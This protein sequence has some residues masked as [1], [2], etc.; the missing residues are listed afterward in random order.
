MAKFG[1]LPARAPESFGV[2][3]LLGDRC[4]VYYDS[5]FSTRHI[6][7]VSD[8]LCAQLRSIGYGELEL[9]SALLFGLYEGYRAQL[10]S[11]ARPDGESLPEPLVIECGVDS[12]KIAVGVSFTLPPSELI[13]VSKLS[14]KLKNASAATRVEKFVARMFA[15]ADQVVIRYQPESR[16]ME[17]VSMLGIPGKI[18]ALPAIEQR[19]LEIFIL[20]PDSKVSPIN[21]EYI[22]LADLDYKSLLKDD[23]PGVPTDTPATGEI[24]AKGV[25]EAERSFRVSG[26]KEEKEKVTRIS[27]VTEHM[28]AVPA[29]ASASSDEEVEVFEEDTTGSE[30]SGVSRSDRRESD[31]Q[32]DDESRKI[33]KRSLK[34]TEVIRNFFG[35]RNS[36]V[37]A[38]EEEL[39]SVLSVDQTLEPEVEA[40]SDEM[41]PEAKML[42]QSEVE[43]LEQT[44]E[45]LRRET[46]LLR[47]E[48]GGSRLQK[49]A[50]STMGELIGE[51]ARVSELAKKLNV[52]YRQKEHEFKNRAN[53]LVEE[54]KRKDELLKQKNSA[55]ER[56]REQLS[57][58]SIAVE[59]LRGQSQSVSNEGPLKQKLS[60][61]QKLL[62]GAKDENTALLRKIE[63]LKAQLIQ[64]QNT[65]SAKSRAAGD[66]EAVALKAKY[67]RLQKQNDEFKRANQ[68]LMEKVNEV[69]KTRSGGMSS[70]EM[71]S[72]LEMAMRLAANY[73]K[74]S[75]QQKLKVEELQREE[76]RLKAELNRSNNSLKAL[77]ASAAAQG[78]R[79]A[80]EDPSGGGSRAA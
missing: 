62:Q 70:D 72:K 79:G 13:D 66:S 32:I 71:K 10:Q 50:E 49:W 39:P 73:Q 29:V 5:I 47:G 35:R 41:D 37:E 6:G 8:L 55:L 60:F 2:A 7:R 42:L 18:E 51:K 64:Q 11:V 9:R 46:Q 61:S 65:S 28:G 34:I 1:K 30:E 12:E 22:E 3:G 44:V 27:G 26:K 31:D 45:R 24:L 19:E 23:G 69:H 43:R 54:L 48:Q 59:R 4:K 76:E 15:D 14:E 67:D 77:K 58:M 20:K 40:P 74:D 21:A 53:Q 80:G 68:V 33:P 78:K 75:E 25:E 56:A 38:E 17:V 57:Q 63:D 36:E 52:S 16:R